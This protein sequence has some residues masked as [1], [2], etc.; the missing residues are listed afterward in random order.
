M[1]GTLPSSWS[2]STRPRTMMVSRRTIRI[3]PRPNSSRFSAI[4]PTV[5]P[6]T[7]FSAHAVA[8]PVP[9]IVSAA[10][11][12]ALGSAIFL[13]LLCSPHPKGLEQRPVALVKLRERL[14]IV[15]PDALD[16]GGHCAQKEHEHV[17]EHEQDQA[18]DRDRDIVVQDQSVKNQD[19]ECAR[20]R[21][22]PDSDSRE[23][24]V[25]K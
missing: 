3:R 18:D 17:R 24:Q 15:E 20:N 1:F 5:A 7:T 12:A 16:G 23:P 25:R 11:I 22:L 14:H 4:A 8:I 9:A 19:V 10:A 21:G 2:A 6:P 13:R